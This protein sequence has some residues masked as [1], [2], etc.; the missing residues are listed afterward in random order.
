MG[1]KSKKSLPY[2]WALIITIWTFVLAVIISLAS[3]TLLRYLESLIVSFFVLFIIMLI[4]IIF[5]VIGIAAAA[6]DETPFHAKAAKKVL[7]AK[8][9]IFLIRNADMVSNFS[10]DVIGDISGIVS[11]TVGALIVFH[12]SNL[13]PEISIVTL[14]ILL[15][16]MIAAFT[17]GGKALGKSL[18]ISQST[19]II[20]LVSRIF[21]RLKYTF[22]K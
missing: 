13:Y 15:T 2:K 16:S 3:Q 1:K 17:V 5:D 19:M 11:G 14:S 21:S 22:K 9:A 4:G 12:I 6:A 7:G 8:D 18:A 10:N 20:L